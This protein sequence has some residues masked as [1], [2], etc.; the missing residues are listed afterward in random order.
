MS[1]A[2]N[3]HPAG[4]V[5]ETLE[6]L[7]PALRAA[8]LHVELTTKRHRHGFLVYFVHV[9]REVREISGRSEVIEYLHGLV[10]GIR[11]SEQD[12]LKQ[13]ERAVRAAQQGKT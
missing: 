6:H 8:G 2:E 11:L 9:N 3:D 4:D 1:P 12:P 7:R 13:L 5:V 10:D